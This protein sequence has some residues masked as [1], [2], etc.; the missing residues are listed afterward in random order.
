MSK[1]ILALDD[2]AKF[3]KTNMI[4]RIFRAQMVRITWK[5]VE[6]INIDSSQLIRNNLKCIVDTNVLSIVDFWLKS[7]TS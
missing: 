4:K 3:Y 1:S 6:F 7:I 2:S 5:I